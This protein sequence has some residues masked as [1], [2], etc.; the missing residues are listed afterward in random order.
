MVINLN[1]GEECNISFANNFSKFTNWTD[2]TLLVEWYK[3]DQFYGSME[4]PSN[5]WGAMPTEDI[6]IW[7]I[8]IPG[9]LSYTNFLQNKDVL[10]NTKLE[11]ENSIQNLEEFC[12]QAKQMHNCN[13]YVYVKNSHL[14]NLKSD[15]YQTLKLNQSIEHMALGLNKTF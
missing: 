12:K 15:N 1:S 5:T 9:K 8:I 6:S 14:L 3:N 2:K 7:K 4:I 10:I 13:I 11:S